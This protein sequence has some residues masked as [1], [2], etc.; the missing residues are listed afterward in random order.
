[1]S[2]ISVQILHF[3]PVFLGIFCKFFS[4]LSFFLPSNHTFGDLIELGLLSFG[5]NSSHNQQLCCMNFC[6]VKSSVNFGTLRE[7]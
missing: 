6:G 2:F 3:C 5:E 1:M 4:F 7:E